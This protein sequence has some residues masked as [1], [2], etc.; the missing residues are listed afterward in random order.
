MILVEENQTDIDLLISDVIMTGKD[1]VQLADTLKEKKEDLKI[2]LSSGY[3]DKK[4]SKS[5]IKDKGYNFIQ[6]PYKIL[7]LLKIINRTLHQN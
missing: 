2:I 1:G 4:V 3:S 5:N 6:K 7:K